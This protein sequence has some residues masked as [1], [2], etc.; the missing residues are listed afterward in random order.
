VTMSMCTSLA[1]STH[2]AS[3]TFSMVTPLL[4]RQQW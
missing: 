1:D 3:H 4:S 2:L